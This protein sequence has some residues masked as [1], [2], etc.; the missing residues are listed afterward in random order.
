M[1]RHYTDALTKNL[2][3]REDALACDSSSKLELAATRARAARITWD[4]LATL[5]AA[6]AR[7]PNDFE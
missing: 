2:D 1:T 5:Q 7:N 3:A 6:Y 4:V